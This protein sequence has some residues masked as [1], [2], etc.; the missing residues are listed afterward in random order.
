MENVRVG[1]SRA[2]KA[3]SHDRIV[4][5]AAARFRENGVG[6]IAVADLMKD[7]GLTHGGFYRH[8]ASRD[9]LVAEAIEQALSEGARAVAAVAKIQDRPLNALALVDAYLST[10][11]RD[12]LATSCAVTTLA[13]DVARGNQRARSAYTRQVGAYLELLTQLISGNTQRARRRKALAALSTLVGAVSMAR[14]VNDE[15]L[16]REILDSVADELKD[17]LS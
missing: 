8:F 2:E 16:S 15:K 7:A 4:Q 11:H 1:H 10:A 9:E 5:V 13:A 6:G 14:A 3:E 12:G 17:E